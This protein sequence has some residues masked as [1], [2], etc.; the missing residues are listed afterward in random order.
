[1]NRQDT[2]SLLRGDRAELDA[3]GVQAIGV[4]GSVA[5]GEAGPD[6][7]VDV[8]VTYRPGKTP[9]LFKFVELKQH[10]EGV[11]G[12]PVDLATP[13]A[14]HPRLKERILAEAVYA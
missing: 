11:L 7:D 6:S 13:D 10:L 12:H 4:F 5:R 9:G 14:L 3:F 2:L 1:M 8:L